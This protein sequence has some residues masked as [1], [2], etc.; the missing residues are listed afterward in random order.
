MP[1]NIKAR[2]V[3][4]AVLGS[5]LI[6]T[7]VARAYED[8]PFELKA[9][10]DD[11]SLLVI[12]GQVYTDLSIEYK[13][14]SQQIYLNG[15][16]IFKV[17]LSVSDVDCASYYD[18]NPYISEYRQAG[19]SCSEAMLRFTD[20]LNKLLWDLGDWREGAAD[21]GVSQ[22]AVE[23]YCE[24]SSISAAFESATV[25]SGDIAV[26]F[27]G[28]GRFSV[29]RPSDRHMLGTSVL[30]FREMFLRWAKRI[31]RKVRHP[32]DRPRLVVVTSSLAEQSGGDVEAAKAQ[33]A[34]IRE[35]GECVEGPISCAYL[36]DLLTP[37]GR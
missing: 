13:P 19:L 33:I 12:A 25:G 4:V 18:D 8:T 22:V 7:S 9:T 37:G 5:V 30:P 10:V 1:M 15:S 21:S 31:V 36:R 17:E 28:F 27:Q 2:L 24:S 16:P 35:A 20:E 3:I 26:Q 34:A 29:P 23:E 32:Q 14:G 6:G 11:S